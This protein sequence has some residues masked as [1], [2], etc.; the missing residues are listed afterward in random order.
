MSY[1]FRS[2]SE[3][4][5]NLILKNGKIYEYIDDGI[6]KVPRLRGSHQRK[7][8]LGQIVENNKGIP[9]TH[10]IKFAIEYGGI[11][12]KVTEELLKQ[13]EKEKILESVKH[14]EST[15]SK[16]TWEK[17]SFLFTKKEIYT[18]LDE[19][20][21]K[22]EKRIKKLKKVLKNSIDEIEQTN[23]IYLCAKMIWYFDWK[24]YWA[25]K[26]EPDLNLSLYIKRY[27]S[28]KKTLFD[29][30]WNTNPPGHRISKLVSDDLFSDAYNAKL[31]FE[32]ELEDFEYV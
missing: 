24:F 15:N 1:F 3:M 18:D 32:E 10:I 27:E 17:V 16:R 6:K 2:F 7:N 30:A 12:K 26:L 11:P 5:Y 22:Y 21:K 4:T 13:L 29:I 31:T 14:G 28:L 23:L 25:H 8:L 20:L 9:H 19:I